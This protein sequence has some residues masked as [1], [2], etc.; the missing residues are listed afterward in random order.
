MKA[1]HTRACLM[2]VYFPFKLVFT[3]IWMHVAIK[4]NSTFNSELILPLARWW[5]SYDKWMKEI[6]LNIYSK[7][8]RPTGTEG[9]FILVLIFLSE[10][11]KK[12]VNDKHSQADPNLLWRCERSMKHLSEKL[13]IAQ[14]MRLITKNWIRNKFVADIFCEIS[15]L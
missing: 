4:F 13:T 6:W 15:F 10:D 2:Q 5:Y 1:V 7:G 14:K 3:S 8:L 11:K 9:Y 12:Y